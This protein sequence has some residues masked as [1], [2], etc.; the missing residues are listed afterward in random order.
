[1]L[2]PHDTRNEAICLS[3]T[4]GL[5]LQASTGALAEATAEVLPATMSDYTICAVYHRMI[6]GSIQRKGRNLQVIEDLERE[7]MDSLIKTAKQLARKEYG[8]ELA[9]ELFLDEWRAILAD[10]TD[11]IN[12]NYENVTRLKYR[13]RNRCSALLE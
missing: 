1:M 10:M 13:Y 2:M 8:D 7:K 4:F 3:I 5:L 12:R 6:I 9:E 11:Q